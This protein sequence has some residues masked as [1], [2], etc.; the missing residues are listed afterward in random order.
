MPHLAFLAR[1][2]L[3]PAFRDFYSY[4]P[5]RRELQTVCHWLYRVVIVSGVTLDTHLS[6]TLHSH[7]R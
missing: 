5:Q 4:P 7:P 1:L 2:P 3:R 6:V